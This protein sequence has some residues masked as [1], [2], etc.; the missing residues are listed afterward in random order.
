MGNAGEAMGTWSKSDIV[1]VNQA[2][3]SSESTALSTGTEGK[4]F[5]AKA[6]REIIDVLRPHSSNGTLGDLDRT[7]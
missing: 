7:D 2:N 3:G 4:E 1:F 6:W 5:Q